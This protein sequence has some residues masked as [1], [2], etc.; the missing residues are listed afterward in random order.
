MFRKFSLITII[1]LFF[2]MISMAQVSQSS[3]DDEP[4]PSFKDRLYTGGTL[5]LELGTNTFINI[6][7]LI[8]YK[9]TE[10]F[11]AGVGSTYQYFSTRYS[12]NE[13]Y[14]TSIY[15]GQLFS[16]YSINEQF[17]L[18]SEYQLLNMEVYDPIGF[19]VRRA[20]VPFLYGGGGYSMPL[21]GRSALVGM[22]L[23]D[24]LD[25]RLSPYS[26]LQYRAGIVIGI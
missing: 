14:S 1:C 6:S 5:G 25:H 26:R 4:K 22:I 23:Y 20:T 9:I 16:R 21:G 8:G 18:H 11:S 13:K 12:A 2:S 19:Q 17:F 24:L 3:A 7:P 10:K 15:G